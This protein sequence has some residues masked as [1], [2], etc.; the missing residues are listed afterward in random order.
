MLHAAVKAINENISV[1]EAD[2]IIMR[3]FN[4]PK[5]GVFGLIDVVGLDLVPPVLESLLQ[6]VPRNDEYHQFDEQPEIFHYMLEKSLIGRKADGGFYKLG[7][8]DGKKMK[9]SLNLNTREYSISK[10]PNIDSL[11]LGKK[12]IKAFLDCSDKYSNYAWA[13]LSET[14]CYVL[15][16]VEE[17]SDDI[18]S[19]DTAMREGFG[20]KQGPFELIDA[21]GAQWLRDKLKN[22]KKVIPDLL[23]KI[24]ESTF[25]KVEDNQIKMFMHC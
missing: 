13:V 12:N 15:L 18:L 16:H 11:N 10:Q 9:H 21:L 7:E 22:S 6:G 3:V 4:A 23:H 8:V 1:E 5:T 17:L 20:L 2:Q 24:G 19:V 14:L 25:Y